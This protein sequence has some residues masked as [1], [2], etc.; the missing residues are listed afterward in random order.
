MKRAVHPVE[1][2][3]DEIRQVLNNLIGN[4][5]DSMPMGGRQLLRSREAMNYKTGLRELVI[6]VADTGGGMS[7]EVQRRLFEAFYTT[8]GI[9]GTGLGLSISCEIVERHGGSLRFR[10]RTT[11]DKS[12]TVFNLALPFTRVGETVGLGL[13]R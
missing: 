11:P 10:S 5:I 12:G 1:C 7:E 4:A 3:G 9:H 8:K 2:L 13:P 6:S